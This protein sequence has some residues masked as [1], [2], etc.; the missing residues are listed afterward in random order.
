M[1]QELHRRAGPTQRARPRSATQPTTHL[2]ERPS[3]C[4][5]LKSGD[6]AMLH[7]Q[8]VRYAASV[9]RPQLLARTRPH[10]HVVIPARLILVHSNAGPINNSL[11]PGERLYLAAVLQCIC[12]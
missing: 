7:A 8:R 2:S 12:I 3:F 1:T 9:S 10:L 4:D 5:N 11:E 6:A